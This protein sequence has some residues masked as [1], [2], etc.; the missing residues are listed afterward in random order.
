MHFREWKF[1]ISITISQKFVPKGIIDNNHALV[2]NNGLAPNRRQ[3]IIWTNTDPIFWR[4]RTALGED[5]LITWGF[6]IIFQLYLHVF[7]EMNI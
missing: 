5:E 2:L 1:H 7:L 6:Y 4:I 3:A